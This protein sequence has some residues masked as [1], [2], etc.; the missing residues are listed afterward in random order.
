MVDW[1]QVFKYESDGNVVLIKSPKVLKRKRSGNYIRLTYR[2]K[3]YQAHRVVWEMFNGA[4]PE[5]F[6][7]D[8]I[9]G[10]KDDNRIE[11][12]RLVTDSINNRNKGKDSRNKSGYNGVIWNKQVSKWQ[13]HIRVD[14]KSKHLGLFLEIGDAVQARKQ[15]E[16]G[17]GF[18]SRHGN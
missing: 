6:K 12:L 8:H 10:M 11:N 18:T 7:V 15:A 16:E 17:L 13:A 9:N 3:S 5:G 4:I 14:G 2:G 1:H